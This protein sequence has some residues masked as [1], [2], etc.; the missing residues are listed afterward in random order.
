CPEDAPARPRP[1]RSRRSPTHCAA[2]CS[3]SWRR[4]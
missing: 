4:G 2:A 3:I 1:I